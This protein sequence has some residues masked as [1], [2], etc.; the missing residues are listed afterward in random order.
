MPF[1]KTVVHHL[2]VQKPKLN[3]T[4]GMALSEK[5]QTFRPQIPSFK[6]LTIHTEDKGLNF[7]LF[8]I[9]GDICLY[10]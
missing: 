5:N 8:S 3:A 1:T 4:K 10:G 2:M 7:Q 9:F 6:V